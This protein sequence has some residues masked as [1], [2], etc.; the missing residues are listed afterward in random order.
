MTLTINR[1][2]FGL[3]LPFCFSWLLKKRFRLRKL[4]WQPTAKAAGHTSKNLKKATNKYTSPTT[5]FPFYLSSPCIYLTSSSW[6]Q[7]YL[8]SLTS[9]VTSS[10]TQLP[11]P[12]FLILV[13]GDDNISPAWPV[14]LA[15]PCRSMCVVPCQSVA[16]RAKCW[17]E[18]AAST[19]KACSLTTT[20][21]SC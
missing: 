1:Y 20:L 17:I 11:P 18:L 6:S 3:K 4:M 7:G 9:Q 21:S 2:T 19:P 16:V 14:V 13:G 5:F 10:Y 15:P 12:W 8:T